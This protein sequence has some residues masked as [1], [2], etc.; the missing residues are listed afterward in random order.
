MPADCSPWRSAS[1]HS[2]SIVP[3]IWNTWSRPWVMTIR[4]PRQ[5]DGPGISRPPAVPRAALAPHAE[6]VAS[7]R[8][9]REACQLYSDAETPLATGPKP[10][11]Q[12]RPLVLLGVE[13]ALHWAQP[14][15]VEVHDVA[16][17]A[18]GVV[19]QP[20][21]ARVGERLDEL[22]RQG[23]EARRRALP[24]LAGR[25]AGD[26]RPVA[27]DLVTPG[28]RGPALRVPIAKLAHQAIELRRVV[29]LVEREVRAQ[30]LGRLG[31]L[32]VAGLHALGGVLDV[33]HRA[34]V[35]L[36]RRAVEHEH[37]GAVDDVA[38]RLAPV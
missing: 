22:P 15:H 13:D 32:R 34:E 2:R 25:G 12:R 17:R 23:H 24:V 38:D 28:L 30:R 33:G 7:M 16:P 19:T 14:A 11:A 6:P 35:L 20:G 10:L 4:G 26:G 21:Q 3:G 1:D 8:R 29:G 36:L 9:G 31:Q 27:L 18:D 37:H 5:S